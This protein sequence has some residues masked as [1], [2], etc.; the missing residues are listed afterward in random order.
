MNI[1]DGVIIEKLM[2]MAGI[3]QSVRDIRESVRGL[4]VRIGNLENRR[5]NGNGWRRPALQTGGGAAGALALFKLWEYMAGI[6]HIN[7]PG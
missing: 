5:P 3:E 2:G 1:E 4:G 7:P 6:Q